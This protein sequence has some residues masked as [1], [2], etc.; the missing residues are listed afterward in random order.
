MKE[1][2]NFS[3]LSQSYNVARR[4]YPNELF[5]YLHSLIEGNNLKALDLGC[6]TGISTR[7]L[8]EHGFHAIGLD[9]DEGMLEAAHKNDPEG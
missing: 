7:Q 9:R 4:G 2:N 1:Q 8:K 6:G 5:E 3:P